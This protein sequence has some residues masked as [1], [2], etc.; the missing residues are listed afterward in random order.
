MTAL[1]SIFMLASRGWRRFREALIRPLFASHGRNFRFD[2]DG[3][4]SFST[5]SVGDDVNLGLR[6]TLMA[7]QSH[8]QI[9]SYVIFGPEVIIRGGNHRTDMVGRLM[10][11]VTNYEKRPKDDLGVVIGDDVW[12]GTRAIILHGVTVGRGAV[13]GA[14]AVVTRNIPPYAI[15]AGNPARVIRFRWDVGTILAHEQALYSSEKRL[16]REYLAQ[17]QREGGLVQEKEAIR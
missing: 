1:V 16:T 4:Y 15:V 2:P 8:I 9:G 10:S 7:T 12:V 17:W 11:S 3:T 5:I 6:P 14:G 13:V